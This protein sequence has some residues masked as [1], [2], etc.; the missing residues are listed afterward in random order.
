MS[1]EE[2][3]LLVEDRLLRL[4][5]LHLAYDPEDAAEFPTEFPERGEVW[6]LG[7]ESNP[8]KEPRYFTREEALAYVREREERS[9][10]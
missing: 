8:V 7:A 9:S 10:R 1:E 4:Y 2:H 6:Q 3:R 5:G